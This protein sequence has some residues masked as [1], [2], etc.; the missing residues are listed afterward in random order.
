[1]LS[2][3]NARLKA[4]KSGVAI[5]QRG[6]RLYALATYPPKDGESKPKQ[7]DLPLGFRANPAGLKQAEKL[8]FKISSQLALKEFNWADWQGCRESKPQSEREVLT[9]GEWLERLET[10]YFERRRR[11]PK[12]ETTWYDDYLKPLK[13]LPQDAPI[14]PEILRQL[15]V[16]TEPDS[17]TRQRY[18][19]AV[20]TFARFTKVDFDATP[21][22][23]NYSPKSLTP[24]VLSTDA[25]IIELR[26]SIT[27]LRWQY[28]FG[29]LG[30]Y[31]LR[32]HELCYIDLER[33]KND[34][35]LVL[36]E[37]DEDNGGKTGG[38]RVPPLRREWYQHW[39]LTDTHLMPIINGP[40]NKA[41][42]RRVGVELKKYGATHL[43][44]LRHAW[45]VR[46]SVA[47]FTAETAARWMGHSVTV[48]ERTYHAWLS[49]ASDRQIYEAQMNRGGL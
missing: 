32:P 24:R 42:G 8:A 48:H 45:A 33:L 14:S 29:L 47:G 10:N 31:G 13:R 18:C 5:R 46:A 44:N 37:I 26:D 49:E 3:I 41:K 38:R 35:F 16:S 7:R 12:S 34:E 22:R 1:M 17:R 25:E 30:T 21:L 43:Y 23:G 11:S 19:M 39:R 4:A 36:T 15:V 9:I 20:N 2:E 28:A 6:D 40:N 27:N